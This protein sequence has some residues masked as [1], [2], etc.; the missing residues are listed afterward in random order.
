MKNLFVPY[1]IAK[2]LKEKGFIPN[3]CGAY[4]TQEDNRLI[5]FLY[6]KRD[7]SIATHL[8]AAPTYQQ[9]T[10]WLRDEHDIHLWVTTEVGAIL[11]YCWVFT[12]ENT[13][14]KHKAY[15]KSYYEALTD[16][17]EQALK[18][19]SGIL[20]SG[21][22]KEQEEQMLSAEEEQRRNVEDFHRTGNEDRI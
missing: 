6:H 4:Q 12:G 20:P 21:Y 2:Q 8:L 16:G 18:L 15:F 9:V 14:T 11:T 3:M 5:H 1:E 13:G 19:F 17:I 22:T 10:D 7:F